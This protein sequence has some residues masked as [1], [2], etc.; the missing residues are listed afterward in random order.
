MARDDQYYEQRSLGIGKWANLIMGVLGVTAAMLSNSDALMVDGLYSAVNFVSAIIAGRIAFSV[1]KG[2]DRRR[3]FGYDANESI[4]ITFRSLVL[5]G[6]LALAFFIAVDK[7]IT[8]AGGGEVPELNFGPIVLYTITVVIICFSLA[9]WHHGNWRKTGG[10][11]DILKTERAASVIDGILSTGAG[12]ALV[13]V[14]FLRGTA[15][16]FI[17]PISDAIIVIVLAA[18]MVGE[19][20]RMLVAA[21]REVAG[22][23]VDEGTV[24][25]VR[26]RVRDLLP[27]T[28]SLL[29][30]AV[31]KLGR[32]YF[33]VAYIRPD[34]AVEAAQMDTL[35]K[36]LQE[37]YQSLLQ[38]V[39]SEAVFTTESPF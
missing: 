27:E 10:R 21:I 35:R 14:T 4:Y 2:A 34:G 3:P 36:D 7:I 32:S 39:K 13:A 5:I 28:C 25:K 12:G 11:S 33:V 17:V 31:T 20:V 37:E 15:L 8:Y 29:Q 38:P 16:D 6:I 30:V 24:T 26:E 9:A 23:S 18:L 1:T 19:P 22:E